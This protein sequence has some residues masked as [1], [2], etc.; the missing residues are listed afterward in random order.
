VVVNTT[1]ATL[2]LLRAAL[3]FARSRKN[4]AFGLVSKSHTPAML[5]K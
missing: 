5:F 2:F 3:V 1:I 4:F